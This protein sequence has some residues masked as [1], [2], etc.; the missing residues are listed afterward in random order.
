MN[1]INI[2][3]IKHN[4]RA[5]PA[6]KINVSTNLAP[7]SDEHELLLAFHFGREPAL[8][9]HPAVVSPGLIPITDNPVYECWW[10]AGN[11]AYRD[12][13]AIRVAECHDY[14]VAVFQSTDGPSDDMAAF[15]H[16]AYR[17][18]FRAIES[19]HHNGPVKIWNYLG[20][21]NNGN[22]DRERYRQFSAG[23]AQAF[24]EL[25]LR[26][27]DTPTGTAIGTKFDFG[28]TVIAL[29]TNRDFALTENPRQVSAYRYPRQY[30]PRSPKF[31]RGGIVS[32]ENHSLF[33]MSGTASVVGHKSV[34]PYDVQLQIGETLAN[35]E[36]LCASASK[37]DI[38]DDRLVL[39]DVSVL[40]VY[41]R[42]MDD[43]NTIAAALRS[44][45]RLNN[46]QVVFLH[47]EICRRELMVEID[48]VMVR[49]TSGCRSE[50]YP[51]IQDER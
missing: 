6:L 2:D 17:Q 22:D 30:G 48:G 14:S 50:S 32:T 33:L 46:Q 37:Q 11:V 9:D 51:E 42:N 44:K 21:I 26:D 34:H 35:I 15:T 4:F 3:R 1:L 20:G 18:L 40:R 7:P 45:L 31:S 36:S 47:G 13:G 5:E 12:A 10:Y 43:R 49:E 29:A 24:H 28:L 27:E 19:C 8:I 23:R 38:G 16:Y 25:S 41:L 39:D